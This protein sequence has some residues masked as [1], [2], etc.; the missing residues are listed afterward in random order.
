MEKSKK[1]EDAKKGK[2]KRIRS[3]T[4]SGP[5]T[6]EELVSLERPKNVKLTEELKTIE[7]YRTYNEQAR[8]NGWRL[9]FPPEKLHQKEK[10][11]VTRLDN[12]EKNPIKI[13]LQSLAHGVEIDFKKIIV[14]GEV[15]ELPLPVVRHLERLHYPEY[16]EIKAPDGTSKTMQVGK[17]PRFAISYVR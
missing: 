17:K 2:Y 13:R 14:P 8:E 12:Q 1:L 3:K 6:R 11:K 7:D 15:Y 9:K 5:V 16:K 4:G 10:V